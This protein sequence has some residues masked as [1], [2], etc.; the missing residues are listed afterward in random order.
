MTSDESYKYEFDVPEENERLA[1]QHQAVKL[2]MGKLV[3]APMDISREGLRILDAGTSDGYW[4]KE[5]GPSLL[6]RQTCELIG[7]DIT[8]ERFPEKPEGMKLFVQNSVGPFPDSWA[9]SFDLVHQRFTLSGIPNYKECVS[10]LLGLVKPGGWIQLVEPE[11]ISSE[12]NGPQVKRFANLVKIFAINSGS[13]LGFQNGGLESALRE[14]G[15]NR[16][17]T[18]VAPVSFGAECPEPNMREQTVKAYCHTASQ[19]LNSY[20][21]HNNDIDGMNPT[22]FDSYIPRLADEL[23]EKG[24]YAA[25]RVVWAQ[26]PF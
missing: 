11:D 6:H 15:F 4:L 12:P 7:T 22:G 26:R 17:G 9:Q 21:R 2:G 20:K 13:D 5:I 24:G 10:A 14:A 1:G 19:F 23:R 25:V 8:G 16:V 18:M 3:L